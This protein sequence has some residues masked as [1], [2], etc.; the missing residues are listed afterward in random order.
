VDTEFV[1]TEAAVAAAAEMDGIVA[2]AAP[3]I[4][5][6]TEFP[7]SVLKL[8]W[9]IRIWFASIWAVLRAFNNPVAAVREDTDA[10][11]VLKEAVFTVVMEPIPVDSVFAFIVLVYSSDASVDCAVICWAFS[12]L[13][14]TRPL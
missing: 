9:P 3:K 4:P 2:E 13:A 11:C 8:P 6:E 12:V 10:V 7:A 14:V 1:D 5:V